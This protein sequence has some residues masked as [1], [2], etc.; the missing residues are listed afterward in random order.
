[1]SLLTKQF[2]LLSQALLSFQASNSSPDMHTFYFW[3]LLFILDGGLPF[4]LIIGLVFP[5]FSWAHAL[6]VSWAL[7]SVPSQFLAFT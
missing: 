5:L 1:M 6:A 7:Y 3:V 2:P 4:I